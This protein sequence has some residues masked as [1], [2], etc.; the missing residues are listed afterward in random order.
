M[1]QARQLKQWMS[2]LGV[3]PY[4]ASVSGANAFVMHLAVRSFAPVR[5][6]AEKSRKFITAATGCSRELKIRLPQP[7]VIPWLPRL[8]ICR[9]ACR[10]PLGRM[11]VIIMGVKHRENADLPVS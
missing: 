7:D 5:S 8:M 10:Q 3:F 4:S 1:K 9:T 2:P 11:T 6:C